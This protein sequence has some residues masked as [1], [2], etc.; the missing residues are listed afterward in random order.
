[1]PVLIFSGSGWTEDDNNVLKIL[2]AYGDEIGSY[3]K[4]SA[5]IKKMWKIRI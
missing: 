5:Y 3:Y 4:Y 2:D 1:M